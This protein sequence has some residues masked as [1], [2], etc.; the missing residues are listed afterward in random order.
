MAKILHFFLS[1]P[2]I[3]APVPLHELFLLK[4]ENAQL[5]IFSPL[6]HRYLFYVSPQLAGLK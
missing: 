2:S 4:E 3:H 6:M 5:N 1:Q